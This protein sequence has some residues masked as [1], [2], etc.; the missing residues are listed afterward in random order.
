MSV[1][2]RPSARFFRTM[3]SGHSVLGLTV[4]LLMY[5]ICVSGTLVVFYKEFW[6]WELATAT[7]ETLQVD[8]ERIERAMGAIF[9]ENDTRPDFIGMELPVG[10]WP[11]MFASWDG[12]RRFIDPEGQLEGPVDRPWSHFLARLHFALNLPLEIG[13]VV[14]GVFGVLLT[15]LILSGFLAHPGIVRDAFALR[16]GRSR[17]LQQTDLHNRLSV[18]GAPFHLVIAV[19]GAV[20][21]LAGVMTLLS[22][23]LLRGGDSGAADP[24]P[25]D[26][27]AEQSTSAAPPASVRVAWDEFQSRYPDQWP[28]FIALSEPGTPS[29]RVEIHAL[30]PDRLY[31]T[32]R[33]RFNAAGEFV[34]AVGGDEA[35][36]GARVQSSSFRLHFGNFAGM[37]VKIAYLLLGAG[38]CVI[39]ATG[40]NIWLAK[41]Q[42][43]GL[44]TDRLE[45][46]W[47]AAVWGTLL[48]IP[49]SAVTWLIAA[50]PPIP[51]FW[52]GLAALMGIAWYRGRAES[53]SSGLRLAA[54]VTSLAVVV[55]HNIQ[56][57][58]AAWSGG[59]LT[60]N[61]V[62]LAM[63][64]GLFI[65]Y[66]YRR[67]AP[68]AATSQ[69]AVEERAR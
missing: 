60:V 34:E 36:P 41:R 48:L 43:R 56:F 49:L 42:Q 6:R 7:T 40:V 67:R 32:Q 12:Q 55:V 64:A 25:T 69:R 2:P 9:E 35:G 17:Q 20:L 27:V 39:A 8:G 4:A 68:A 18:W 58:P 1:L 50:V 54:G 53:W 46:A 33:Y 62:W 11:R 51:V 24:A 22:T 28:S 66:L 52:G 65:P 31:W 47:L 30:R 29:Q 15:A 21:G 3:L 26:S 19:T 57:G 45:R 23:L 38:L 5:V 13:V 14:V 16:L 44:P 63:A 10:D 59:S 37:P 61:T